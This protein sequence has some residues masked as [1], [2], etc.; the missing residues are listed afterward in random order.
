[1]ADW[2]NQLLGYYNQDDAGGT[3]AAARE[4]EYYTRTIGAEVERR[5]AEISNEG[6]NPYITQLDAQRAQLGG[7][8]GAIDQA[9]AGA[10]RLRSYADALPGQLRNS[11]L[12]STQGASVASAN[13]ARLAG[14]GRGGMAFGGGAS[15]LAARGA[16]Q[17]SVQQGA[18]LAN[19]MLGATQA[20]MQAEQAAT[21]IEQGAVQQTMG[22]R[23][24]IA[25]NTMA[26]AGL[27]EQF[28]N[29]LDSFRLADIQM[30]SSLANSALAG[31]LQGD[32]EYVKTGGL[33]S[34]F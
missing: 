2:Y 14:S 4:W 19:A 7:L 13:A 28:T 31:G 17:A 12:A 1:M 26:A 5:M 6:I 25:Q 32:Q 16:Q 11:A 21:G 34:I 29:R 3:A 27:Q 10:N 24:M 15:A 20:R 23:N 30:R 18:A 8:Q 33:L 22:L 9:A